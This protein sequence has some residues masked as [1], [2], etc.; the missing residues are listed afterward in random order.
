MEQAVNKGCRQAFLLE[1]LLAA[2]V[3]LWPSPL[4]LHLTQHISQLWR[5]RGSLRHSDLLGN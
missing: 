3:A 4:I 2:A 5:N 1:R